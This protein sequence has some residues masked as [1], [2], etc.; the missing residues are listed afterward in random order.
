MP[1]HDQLQQLMER[2]AALEARE[3]SLT[4]ASSVYQTVITTILANLDKTTRDNIIATID[5][6][7]DIA[8]V[9]AIHS[10]DT[11][12]QQKI[13]QADDI[14]QRIFTFAQ[15]DTSKE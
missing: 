15:G 3:K 6:A 9:R 4:A 1:E 2:V 10:R 8:Y 11:L 7:Y 13:K 12:Q 14:A 5:Q